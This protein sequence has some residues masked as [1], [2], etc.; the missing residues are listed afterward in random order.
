MLRDIRLSQDLDLSS[1]GSSSFMVEVYH[2]LCCCSAASAY[3]HPM[4]V[5]Y[6]MADVDSGTRLI[7]ESKAAGW[8]VCTHVGASSA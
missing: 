5:K 1:N 2:E 8:Y 4:E 6:V 7:F 3:P